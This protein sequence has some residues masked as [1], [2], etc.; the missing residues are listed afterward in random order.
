MS[1]RA[2]AGAGEWRGKEE[3]SV[4][5]GRACIHA[6]EEARQDLRVVKARECAWAVEV[7]QAGAARELL[8]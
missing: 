1:S 7:V 6:A 2:A 8:V 3:G 5:D 4:S